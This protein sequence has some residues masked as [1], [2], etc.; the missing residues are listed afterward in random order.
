MGLW[1]YSKYIKQV[2]TQIRKYRTIEKRSIIFEQTAFYKTHRTEPEH[3]QSAQSSQYSMT[4]NKIC[5]FMFTSTSVLIVFPV[6]LCRCSL[7]SLTMVVV[8]SDILYVHI[9]K[10]ALSQSIYSYCP[11]PRT[12]LK[13]FLCSYRRAFSLLL[14]LFKRKFNCSYVHIWQSG[15]SSILNKFTLL[16]LTLRK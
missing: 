5:L 13:Q 15:F 2:R 6:L 10:C 12:I 3:R 1:H 7:C 16:I 9:I 8:A 11:I 4:Y 14:I